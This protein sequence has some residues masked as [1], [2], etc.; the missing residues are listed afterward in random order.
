MYRSILIQYIHQFLFLNT[1]TSADMLPVFLFGLLL[2]CSAISLHALPQIMAVLSWQAKCSP[3]ETSS[4][5]ATASL[6]S[7]SSKQAA[8]NKVAKSMIWSSQIEN[9][10]KTSR[11]NSVV[12]LDNGNLVIRD[13]SNPSNMW[14]QSFDHPK[15][16]LPP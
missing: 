13:A 10:P 16:C 15:R 4:S 7:A 11:N 2:S 8:V 6:L 3:V 14:W 1:Q 5:Q 12:L 9:R